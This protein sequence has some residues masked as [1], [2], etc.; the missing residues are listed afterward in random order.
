MNLSF[1]LMAVAYIANLVDI[2][3]F[4]DPEY[5]ARQAGVG[6]VVVNFVDISFGRSYEGVAENRVRFSFG[7]RF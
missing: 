2:I 5:G 3:Y 4:T 1:G 7:R 6:D